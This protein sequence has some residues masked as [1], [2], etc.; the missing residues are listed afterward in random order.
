MRRRL[1]R[2]IGERSVEL[3]GLSQSDIDGAQDARRIGALTISH[4]QE[5]IALS[6]RRIWV[7]RRNRQFAVGERSR[8]NVRI[9]VES[10]C[11]R[12]T[13]VIHV[14]IAE[15]IVRFLSHLHKRNVRFIG[16]RFRE[17][18]LRFV[19]IEFILSITDL[20]IVLQ[21]HRSKDVVAGWS[22]KG[23][24]QGFVALVGHIRYRHLIEVIA[25]NVVRIASH[26]VPSNL[27]ILF[28]VDFVVTR[29]FQTTI[30]ALTSIHDHRHLFVSVSFRVSI[31]KERDIAFVG[32]PT[33]GRN[34]AICAQHIIDII[35]ARQR[36]FI[37]SGG[38]T[39]KHIAVVLIGISVAEFLFSHIG[40]HCSSSWRIVQTKATKF[41][42]H[43]GCH[44]ELHLRLI[45]EQMEHSVVERS[46]TESVETK[47][48]PQRRFSEILRLQST[49]KLSFVHIFEE[50]VFLSVCRHIV[51]CHKV[52]DAFAAGSEQFHR[53]VAHS[54]VENGSFSP[55]HMRF[56]SRGSV[57]RGELCG[58]ALHET[59]VFIEDKKIEFFNISHRGA[60]FSH[61]I[62]HHQAT[63]QGD[64]VALLRHRFSVDNFPYCEFGWHL[65]HRLTSDEDTPSHQHEKGE[66]KAFISEI[67][68]VQ[69]VSVY[70]TP[71]Y[72]SKIGQEKLS[73]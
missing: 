51:V 32:F 61:H 27:H 11:H 40:C 63:C 28:E 66:Y 45:A 41:K 5:L 57:A 47:C 14:H 17:N 31:F 19:H 42:V 20:R 25:H 52:D 65:L 26:I 35:V 43:I 21:F 62:G 69:G 6:L 71:L 70:G 2:T 16:G 23:L 39:I 49:H 73:C 33:F 13:F 38:K 48:S 24:L 15:Q 30:H 3:I 29:A 8:L 4:H 59:M 67:H 64:A 37:G 46:G 1:T 9:V 53:E 7:A 36:R 10:R 68:N 12:R 55:W 56:C 34:I 60:S 58:S 72:K 18:H 44:Y 50:I 22:V 54:V